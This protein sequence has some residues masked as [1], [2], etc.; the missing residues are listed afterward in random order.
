MV[1]DKAKTGRRALG[2]CF[3]RCWAEIGNMT[4]GIFRKLMGSLIESTL[5]YGTEIWGCSRRLEAIEQV[6]LCA[7]RMLFGVGTLHPRTSLWFEMEMMPLVWKAKMQCVRFWLKVMSAEAYEG[8]L[9]RKIARHSAWV[10]NMAKCV[11]DFGWSGMG[12]DV[13]KNLSDSEIQEMLESVAWRSVMSIMKEDMEELDKP[14]LSILREIADLR[15]E[16]SCALVKEKRER[17]MLLKL[18]GGTAAFQIKVGRWQGVMRNDR[19]CKEC[20]SGEV[21]DCLPLA[22]TR[23]CLGPHQTA[24]AYTAYRPGMDIWP[25]G[26][27]IKKWTAI[28]L[29]ASC[30]STSIMKCIRSMSCVCFGL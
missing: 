11:G 16:S 23:P 15:L 17:T 21:E 20:Q 4:V 9:L 14:E 13:V 12:V 1:V 30:I 19:V 2:A 24:P 8:R 27:S 3:Q 18:R 25:Q 29:S 7:L 26:I 22:A 10:K 5:M 28:I 6:Q